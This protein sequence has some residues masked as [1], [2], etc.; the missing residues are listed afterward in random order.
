MSRHCYSEINLHIVWHT[1]D[2]RP[3]LIPV[4]EKA[5]HQAVSQRVLSHAGVLLHA[6]N[7]TETHVH[8]AVSIPPTLC[9]SEFIGDVKGSSSH[10]MNQLFPHDPQRFAWQV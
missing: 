5:A 10:A 9:I 4:V 7:G 2:S 3:L 1:K 8:I 6:V